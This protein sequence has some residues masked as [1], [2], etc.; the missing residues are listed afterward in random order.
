MIGESFGLGKPEVKAKLAWLGQ[1]LDPELE[2][3][4][5]ERPVQGGM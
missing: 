1:D 3:Y 4:H 2:V 5:Y